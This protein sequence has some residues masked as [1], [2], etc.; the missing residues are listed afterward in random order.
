MEMPYIIHGE[1]LDDPLLSPEPE[2]TEPEILRHAPEVIFRKTSRE[3]L[4]KAKKALTDGYR[5]NKD[6]MK[7]AWGRVND[8]RRH[9]KAVDPKSKEYD[10]AQQ[11]MKEVSARIKAIEK[12]SV[13]LAK[14][15]MI[16]QRE[17]LADELEF[18]Y[19]AKGLD[20]HIVLSGPDKTSLKME[21]PPLCEVFVLK[22]IR[23]TD[24][25]LY[26]ERAGLR[27]VTLG[28]GEGFFWT[29]SFGT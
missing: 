4:K 11:L 12:V 8:A 15:L 14:R 26:L 9:L 10:E 16:R 1:I 2:L 20:A 7:T 19:L 18:F 28:D 23:D 24:F 25:L 17:M 27:K 6:P 21:C 3:Y 29:H 22:M 5:P 13:M